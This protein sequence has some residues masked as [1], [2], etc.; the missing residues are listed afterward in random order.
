MGSNMRIV[1]AEAWS[2]DMQLTRPY[3]VAGELCSEA[4]NSFIRIRTDSGLV[5]RGAGSPSPRVTGETLESADNALSAAAEFLVGQDPLRLDQLCDSLAQQ[6][7]GTPAARAAVDMALHDLYASAKGKPL[8]ECLGRVHGALPTSVTIG[9]QSLDES[10]AEADEYLALGFRILKL[11]IGEDVEADIEIS[12]RICERL[13][14]GNAL[15]VDGNQGYDPGELERYLTATRQLN[16]ELIEQPFS[17]GRIDDMRAL[18]AAVRQ[19]CAADEDLHTPADARQLIHEPLAF[20]IFNIKLMKCGGV[21]PAMQIAALA[22]SAGIELMWGCMDESRIS[23][24]AALHAALACS[25]TRYLDLDGSLDLA[26][27]IV[28][29]RL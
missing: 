8:V 28:V 29:G 25:A 6:M 27:D 18:P 4:F 21:H 3:A 15:R 26:H 11:K 14:V 23:I 1:E 17:R 7:P 5:G 20:G 9:I 12:H 24:A 19:R 10:L 16:L 22:E 2:E 13:G